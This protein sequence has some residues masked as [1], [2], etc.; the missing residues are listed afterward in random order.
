[1]SHLIPYLASV[2][3]SSGVGIYA[4]RR[5]AVVG[6]RPFAVVALVEA[7]TVVAYILELVS[8][9][10]AMKIFWDNVQWLGAF[11]TP[12]GFLVV[13]QQYTGYKF[14]RPKLVWGTILAFPL[15]FGLLVVTDG[16]HGLLHPAA[17]IIPHSPFPALTYD[18][19]LITQIMGVY[20][21]I[22]PLF[23]LAG[24]VAHYS[25]SRKIYRRQIA[26]ITLGYL[27]PMVGGFI[28]L[29]DVLPAADRDLLPYT[30]ALSNL[31][32]AWG[33]F[34]YGLLDLIPVSYATVFDRVSDGVLVVDQRNRIVDLNPAMQELLGRHD[35][36]LIGQ[37]VA[38][39]P[40]P[41]SN[42][43]PP[44]ETVVASRTEIDA[45]IDGI[46]Q[47]FEMQVSP[48]FDHRGDLN[49]RLFLFRD[50]TERR[51]KEEDLARHREQLEDM[52]AA[53]TAQF[54]ASIELLKEEVTEREFAEQELL[55]S[56]RN[57]QTLFDS[58]D[59]FHIIVDMTG[60]ILQVNP[61]VLTRLGYS[62]DEMLGQSV[63]MI[64]SPDQ[65]QEAGR[66]LGEMIAGKIDSCFIPLMTKTGE[67]I[68]VETKIN[69]GNWDGQPAI[70]G[71]SRDITERNQAEEQLVKE[72]NFTELLINSIPAL[73]YVFNARGEFIRVNENVRRV[74]GYSMREMLQSHPLDFFSD[75][76]KSLVAESIEAILK[77]GNAEIEATVITKNGEK[78]PYHFYGQRIMLDGQPHILG[79]GADILERKQA[80]DL[81]RVQ[82]ELGMALLASPKMA[83]TLEI[84]LD[85]ALR[86][87][88]MDSGGIYLVDETSGIDLVCHR[89]LPPEIL[90]S[91][92][93][94][95]FDSN[96]PNVQLILGGEPVY[97]NAEQLSGSVTETSPKLAIKSLAV[98]P[99]QFEGQ[100]I[101][102]FNISSHTLAE[103]PHFDRT[104]LEA[105]ATQIGTAISRS[106]IEE[107]LRKSEE[108]L[109]S[110]LDSISDLIFVLDR[111]GKFRESYQP[112]EHSELFSLPE[113]F[114]GKHFSEVLPAH[115][116]RLIEQAIQ[117]VATS[118]QVQHFDYP[119]EIGGLELWFSARCAMRRDING[120]F[121]GITIVVRN[122]TE[123]VRA[124]MALRESE[125]RLAFAIEA[126]EG[127][128]YLQ[129]TDFSRVDVD[130]RW[131]QSLGF[132]LSELPAS[133]P[134]RMALWMESVHPDDIGPV[135][136]KFSDFIE[137]KVEKYHAEFRIRHKDGAWRWMNSKG[138]A[139]ERDEHGKVL[140]LAGV[141]FDVTEQKE[142]EAALK[143]AHDELEMRVLNRT[144][145]LQISEAKWRSLIENVPDIIINVDPTGTI[146]SI[147]RTINGLSMGEMVGSS[148][149]D[150]ILPENKSSLQQLVDGVFETGRPESVETLGLG[151]GG[152]FL[153]FS[154]RV[155]PVFTDGKVTAVTIISS[156]ITERKQAE[157]QIKASLEE[158]EVLLKEIHHR[159]K[160]NLQ[161]IASML[162]MQTRYT[163]D[164]RVIEYLMESR[165]R[166]Y[167]M[168]LVHENLYRSETLAQVDAAVYISDLVNNVI[169]SFGTDSYKINL[170]LNV[171]PI[172]LTIDQAV[173]CGL[174]INELVTNALKH[175]FS[176]AAG[177]PPTATGEIK[178]E[179]CPLEDDQLLLTVSDNGVGFPGE[180]D[181][182]ANKTLGLRL[183]RSLARQ[184]D[185]TLDVETR[186]RTIFKLSFKKFK[187]R[188]KK[189]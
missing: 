56:Q 44:I 189:F 63:L 77:T 15:L 86:A 150:Y 14:S 113:H 145:E 2:L 98:I 110:T 181:L 174:I 111:D 106:K 90:Q 137:N 24:L 129:T 47:Y 93:H 183:V 180:I 144:S 171:E 104:V 10:L 52:V 143:K 64:H 160:N 25:R 140:K 112:G 82:R 31:V 167:S 55:D 78:L 65:Y 33:L 22:L 115:V 58:V 159:V 62:A 94:Y 75:N 101:A 48:L 108:K 19:N 123:R 177:P 68:P 59:D 162:G 154:S 71:V 36:N 9:N 29:A 122:I 73:V 102:C 74:T 185:A 114:L 148:V 7:L 105:I 69:A 118:A 156:D 96:L 34:R 27:I 166:I 66:I 84:C 151:P 1:M 142:A 87:S 42:L 89:G 81:L 136:R 121:A 170:K 85:T 117:R 49:G 16:W 46:G 92:Q 99:V 153:W 169:Q 179:L 37:P 184:L 152:V 188:C 3:I 67:L 168:A 130:E 23:G 146:Q 176:L 128:Y 30:F 39:M 158:K 175:G 131:A 132:A 149:Y 45:E 100:V 95:D 147:N 97:F 126:S 20:L 21:L 138:T 125:K 54:S 124:E 79:V 6:A 109:R 35:R 61:I 53:R 41:W 12:I 141:F 26:I 139:V 107:A 172:L 4:W 40:S 164:Q 60:H 134:E 43:I 127:A 116:T 173:P 186:P 119:L 182:N 88:A 57:L 18:F 13:I 157:L 155:G 120:E 70:F 178:I 187:D 165:N 133:G 32:V 83:E 103:V 80:E 51:L 161:V 72:K 163:E 8:S 11:I 28:S 5:R 135:M 38:A 17:R 76:E 91:E 50:I